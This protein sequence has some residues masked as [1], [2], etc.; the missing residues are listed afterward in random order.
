MLKKIALLAIAT[1]TLGSLALSASVGCTDLTD[2]KY[3]ENAC[4]CEGRPN[5][6]ACLHSCNSSL[7]SLKGKARLASCEDEYDNARLCADT[8]TKCVAGRWQLASGACTVEAPA[9]DKCIAAGGKG[10][11]GAGGSSGTTA[12]TGTGN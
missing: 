11:G 2:E 7:A 5:D 12:S 9:L 1:T 10:N 8:Y 4:I 3:C 6:N